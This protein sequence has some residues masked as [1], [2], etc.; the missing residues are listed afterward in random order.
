[1]EREEQWKKYTPSIQI[2]KFLYVTSADIGPLVFMAYNNSGEGDF[3]RES[4]DKILTES[5]RKCL[6]KM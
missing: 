2:M 1:V 6:K 4:R 3:P 5:A